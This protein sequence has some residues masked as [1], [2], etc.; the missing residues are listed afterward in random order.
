MQEQPRKQPGAY[1]TLRALCAF[2]V[3]LLIGVGIYFFSLHH[4]SNVAEWGE[5][6]DRE[7]LICE[8]KTYRL[9]GEVGSAGLSES[10]FPTEELKGEV[11]PSRWFSPDQPLLVWTVKGKADYL[12]VIDGNTSYVYLVEK[13]T[14][15]SSGSQS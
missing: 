9:R 2:A 4:H 1:L 13:E 5:D 15:A 8:E 12:L 14:V 3:C 10:A 7:V 6:G 11:K